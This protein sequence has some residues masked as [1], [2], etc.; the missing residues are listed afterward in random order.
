VIGIYPYFYNVAIGFF[1]LNIPHCCRIAAAEL[2][3]FSEIMN[4]LFL[5]GFEPCFGW[6]QS[7]EGSMAVWG[8]SLMLLLLGLIGCVLPVLP[9][10]MLIVIA[11]IL[12]RWL[13]GEASGVNRGTLIGLVLLWGGAQW[14]EWASGA[15]GAKWFGGSKWSAWGAVLGALI[16]MFFFPFGLLLGPLIGAFVGEK[17]FAQK[18]L[19]PSLSAGV[20]SMVGV[21][22]GMVIQLGIGL[23]MAAWIVIDVVLGA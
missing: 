19:R 18:E 7:W 22:V 21:A 5:F 11:A 17:W 4:V 8:L 13:L 3:H 1:C 6:S 2:L 10:H 12:P 20:G 23:V 14:L 9:G 15:A 16:G